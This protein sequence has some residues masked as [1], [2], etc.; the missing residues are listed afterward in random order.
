MV[1]IVSTSDVDELVNQIKII[2]NELKAYDQKLYKL[3]RWLVLNKIDALDPKQVDAIRSG[4]MKK[5]RWKK[6]CYTISAV[7]GKGCPDLLHAIQNWFN[8]EPDDNEVV[9]KKNVTKSK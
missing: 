5:L 1:D 3:D 8:R 6:P 4:I 7:S 9:V 2:T